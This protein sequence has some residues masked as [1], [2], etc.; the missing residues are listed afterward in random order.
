SCGAHVAE[1]VTAELSAVEG[2]TVAVLGPAQRVAQLRDELDDLA[3][4]ERLSVLPVHRA[5]G[6]EFDAV[7]LVCPD[8][9]VAESARGWRDLYVAATRPTQRLG[10]VHTAE[11]APDDPWHVAVPS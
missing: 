7:V 2:G 10:I 1:T 4:A 11:V 8:E 9:I 5:K 3:G 6:L